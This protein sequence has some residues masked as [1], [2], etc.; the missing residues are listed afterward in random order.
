MPAQVIW[1]DEGHTILCYQYR[2]PWQ[3]EDAYA[4]IQQARQMMADGTNMVDCI[5]D[6]N[7]A[8]LP[9]GNAI[10]QIRK[11]GELGQNMTNYSGLTVFVK[12]DAFLKA[13]L[14]V[15]EQAYPEQASNLNWPHVNS[16]DDA[17]A[18]IENQRKTIA[19]ETGTS[20]PQ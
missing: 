9:S 3:W 14:H 11:L 4:A 12:A 19:K 17:I 5:V 7:G 18:F 20:V 10:I 16:M 6:M 1:V 13:L 8:R 15:H 2:S